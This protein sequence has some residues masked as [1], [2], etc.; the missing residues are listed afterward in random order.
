MM[1]DT[2]MHDSFSVE[3][4][5]FLYHLPQQYTRVYVS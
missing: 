3:K 1:I 2:Y 4:P 5:D